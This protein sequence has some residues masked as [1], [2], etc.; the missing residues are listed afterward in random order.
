MALNTDYDI[1]KAFR[2]IEDELI[3]SMIRNLEHHMAEETKEGFNWTQW[4]V[5]QIK[6]LER[7]KAENKKK[8]T[9][10]FSNINDSI[11]AMIFAARQAGGTEQ[12][13]KILRAIKKGFKAS[14]VS[15][16]TEG[17]FFKLNTRKLDAL[18]KATKAD[19]TRAEHSMLRMSE[20]KYRQIIFNAQ[21]YANTGAGTYEKAVDMATRD[22][23]KA[24]INC[25]EYANGSRHT[26]KD[27]ARMAIQTASKRAYLTGEGEM[28]QSWGISTVIMNKRA[29]ACPKCLPFVGKVLIDDVWSGGKASDGP[30]PL[31]SSAIAAGLYHP[32]CKDVHTTYFPELDEEPDSKFTK[33]ELEKVKE[34]YKQDQKRQYAGRMVEQFDRLSKYSL[35]P[36]NKKMYA[37]RKEQWE[38]SILFNGSSEKHIEELHK[39][40]IMN[41]SDKEL[42]AVT[43]YKSF[44]AYII[45]DVLRNAN[46][47]SNLKSEHKQLVNNLD[48]ALSKISKFNGNLIRTVDFSDRKDEQDRIKEFV[49]EYVEGTIITIKQ[50]WSTSK[51]EGYNDLPKIKIYIQNTKNG[52]DIS[53]IGLNE[54]EVLYERNSKFKVISKILVG[55]IWHILL[56]EAD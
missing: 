50:Y 49:S 35:D 41:L 38:Q 44:E 13:Q 8:F 47:L 29:N 2:A 23:L 22:F 9:K 7:Y 14:K 39:N 16:G 46:D 5:E 31:M 1:E 36:D 33:E 27:Y 45:N 11:E 42:Q 10:S 4:Q 15:Q 43:Q 26:V 21:V 54:N 6:A 25:I 34:D 17:A 40:D 24:G 18:I 32:N 30:Y 51:T 53:S 19:F 20:D 12:E 52:R 48:V 28:R 55:E 56:E 3:A 37:A